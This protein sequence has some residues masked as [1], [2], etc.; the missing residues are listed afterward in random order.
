MEDRAENG[1]TTSRRRNPH[2]QPK[3]AGSRHVENGG[4]DGMRHLRAL[5]PR[6]NGLMYGHSL[7]L[8]LTTLILVLATPI[9]VLAAVQWW[10]W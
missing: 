3:G 4:E 10:H 6:S 2:T 7:F 8:L 9:L 5:I 1:W